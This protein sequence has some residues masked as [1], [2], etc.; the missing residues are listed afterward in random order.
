MKKGSK[1]LMAKVNLGQTMP[2]HMSKSYTSQLYQNAKV[3]HDVKE[4]PKLFQRIEW[5]S[6]SK[7]SEGDEKINS[8]ES[9]L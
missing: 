1:D 9:K 4:L 6:L 5:L 8:L 2:S 7:F 3:N